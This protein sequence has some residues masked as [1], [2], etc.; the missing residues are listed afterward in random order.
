MKT[1]FYLHAR[2]MQGGRI[3]ELAVYEGEHQGKTNT[4]LGAVTFDAAQWEDFR[5][6]LIGGMRVAAHLRVPVTMLDGTRRD[7]PLRIVK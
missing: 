4:L 2:P 7:P 5:A 1:S 6:I 3:V